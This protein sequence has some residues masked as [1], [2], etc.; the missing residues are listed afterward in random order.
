MSTIHSF[1]ESTFFGKELED[2]VYQEMNTTYSPEMEAWYMPRNHLRRHSSEDIQEIAGL[3]HDVSDK[4]HET[5]LEA[6]RDAFCNSEKYT[7]LEKKLA[8]LERAEIEAD[9]EADFYLEFTMERLSEQSRADLRAWLSR[10][11]QGFSGTRYD[12]RTMWLGHEGLL[13]EKFVAL[14]EAAGGKE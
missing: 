6:Q 8:V 14:C 13:D 2:W 12:A 11:K 9:V 1:D 10:R 7:T 3:L 4:W 5:I